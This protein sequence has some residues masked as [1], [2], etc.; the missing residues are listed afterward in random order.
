MPVYSHI[1]HNNECHNEWE[2]EYSIKVDP[3]KECPKCHQQTAQRVISSGPKGRVELYG[4]ELVAALK[5]DGKKIAKEAAGNEQKYA[6]LLGADKYEAIQQ[7]I[8][9][10]KRR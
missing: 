9:K 2:D 1:C 6:N 8:D 7:K 10:Q 5:A 4:A 3:P